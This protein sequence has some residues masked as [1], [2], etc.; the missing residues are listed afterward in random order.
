MIDITCYIRFIVNASHEEIYDY[1][2]KSTIAL[3]TMR[4]EHFGMS[5]VVFVV[6]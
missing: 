5:M 4:D 3:H 1:L 6:S 2:S